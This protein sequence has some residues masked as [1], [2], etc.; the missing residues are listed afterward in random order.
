MGLCCQWPVRSLDPGALETGKGAWSRSTAAG[1]GRWP[2]QDLPEKGT[3]HQC[4]KLKLKIIISW[5]MLDQW[6]SRQKLV[7]IPIIHI[8]AS[9]PGHSHVFNVAL[10]KYLT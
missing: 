9:S 4:E 2:E 5:V 8:I 3:L 1:M 7:C 6:G 10:Y